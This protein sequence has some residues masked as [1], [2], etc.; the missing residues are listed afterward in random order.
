MPRNVTAL[1]RERKLG[2]YVECER[3]T[4][5]PALLFLQVTSPFWLVMPLVVLR[6]FWSYRACTWAEPTTETHGYWTDGGDRFEY[7]VWREQLELRTL[8]GSRVHRYERNPSGVEELI[9]SACEP[10]DA[11]PAGYEDGPEGAGP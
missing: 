10:Q 4:P 5:E 9:R 3:T 2:P 11:V 8:D 6:K 1:A 7:R